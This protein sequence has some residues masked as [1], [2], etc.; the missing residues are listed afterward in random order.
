[1]AM[2]I[3]DF[4]QKAGELLIVTVFVFRTWVC[5]LSNRSLIILESKLRNFTS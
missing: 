5:L 2:P 3:N 1:M 4:P